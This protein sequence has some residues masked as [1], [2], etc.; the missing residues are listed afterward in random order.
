MG[1]FLPSAADASALADVSW[2]YGSLPPAP[3]L[4]AWAAVVSHHPSVVSRTLATTL[5]AAFPLLLS[6]SLLLETS[7]QVRPMLLLRIMPVHFSHPRYDQA[8][9]SL[10]RTVAED[11]RSARPSTHA[12]RGR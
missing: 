5:I 12:P 6:G 8:H 10:I 1:A 2:I 4:S 11:L 3:W 7:D 9:T